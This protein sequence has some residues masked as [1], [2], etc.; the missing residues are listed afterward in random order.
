MTHAVP[1]PRTPSAR[2]PAARPRHPAN[3]GRT[4]TGG[5]DRLLSP[6]AA[7]ESRPELPKRK[8]GVALDAVHENSVIP[9]RDLDGT[10]EKSERWFTPHQK[11]EE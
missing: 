5:A 11:P 6:H 1:R 10:N 9:L 8:P 2:T 7:P 3:S 4:P